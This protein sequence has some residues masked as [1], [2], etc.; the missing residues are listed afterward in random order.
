MLKEVRSV[1]ACYLLYCAWASFSPRPPPGNRYQVELGPHQTKSLVQSTVFEDNM[2]TLSLINVPKMSTRNKCLSLKYHFFWSHIGRDKG[3]VIKYVKTTEQK[4]DI[5][6]KGLGPSQFEVI[7]K[8]LMGWQLRCRCCYQC[9]H[10]WCCCFLFL[11]TLMYHT[12]PT[13]SRT[14]HQSLTI[15]PKS[16]SKLAHLLHLPI[17]CDSQFIA[18]CSYLWLRSIP[19]RWTPQYLHV[20]RPTRLRTNGYISQLLDVYIE[21]YMWW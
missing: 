17:L 20:G 7:Q 6:T 14:N 19:S 15:S 10:C 21:I 9:Q 16:A 13:C 2:S 12:S 3:I 1:G 8:L 18:W 5:F 11:E 4:A